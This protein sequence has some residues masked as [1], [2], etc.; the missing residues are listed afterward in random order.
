LNS[1]ALYRPLAVALSLIFV[2][3]TIS[4]Q[5]L[6]Q[7]ALEDTTFTWK[8]SE[9]EQVRI[10]YQPAS[11]ADKHRAMLLRSVTTAVDEVLQFLE[12]S[13]NDRFLHVFYLES[14]QEMERIVGRPVSGLTNWTANGIF[15]VVNPEWRSFETHEITH[16]YTMGVWGSPDASSSWMIEG[17]SIASDGWCR[18][19]TVDEIAFHLLSNGDLPPLG[20]FFDDFAALG[21]IRGGFYA[22]SVIGFIRDTYGMDALRNLWLNGTGDLDAILGTDIDQIDASWKRD[23]EQKVGKE[24]R[25]DL[26]TIDELGCG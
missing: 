2:P 25:V 17:I 13:K 23:L 18:E 12:Q 22:A 4:A 21:E 5:D 7:R 20:A 3:A 19:Y 1:K 24:I 10:Y 6:V 11:F 26:K 14:R 9:T 16:M 15:I 8:S